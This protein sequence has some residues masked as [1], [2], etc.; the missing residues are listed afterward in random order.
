LNKRD[1]QDI[2]QAFEDI[3]Q[4]AHFWNWVPDLQ[5]AKEIYQAFPNSFSVL[6]PF[7]YAYLE[8]LIRSTTSEYGIV[9]TDKDGQPKKRKVGLGLIKLAQ[10]ENKEKNP[11][12]VALLEELKQY[13]R[14]S[15][16]TDKGDNRHSVSHG[17]MHPSYW[18]NESFERLVLDIARLSKH[19]GF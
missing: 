1:N 4:F 9:V 12:Y 15:N 2:F 18:S 6:T 13:Y 8:E 11:E 19:S 3:M 7:I 5:V 16:S 14:P 10:D 17:Y